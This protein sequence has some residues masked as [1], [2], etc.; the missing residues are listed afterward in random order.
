MFD[1]TFLNNFVKTAAVPIQ[2]LSWLDID[3]EEY[4]RNERLPNNK[5]T[6]NSKDQLRELWDH[7]V[8][9]GPSQFSL[10]PNADRKPPLTKDAGV[11]EEDVKDLLRRTRLAMAQGKTGIEVSNFIRQNFDKHTIQAS[12]GGLQ[13]ISKEHGLLGFAYVDPGVFNCQKTKVSTLKQTFP[14]FALKRAKCD[15]CSF[16]SNQTCLKFELP[17]KERIAFSTEIADKFSKKVGSLGFEFVDDT[18]LSPSERIRKIFLTKKEKTSQRLSSF[19]QNRIAQVN[20]NASDVDRLLEEREKQAQTEVNRLKSAEESALVGEVVGFLKTCFIHG[21]YGENAV[22]SLRKRFATENLKLAEKE[23]RSL[24][25]EQGLFGGVYITL[26]ALGGCDNVAKILKEAN[27]TTRF[28]EKMPRCSSC[29]HAK[30]ER[31][32]KLDLV[33]LDKDIP[34]NDETFNYF[35]EAISHKKQIPKETIL[36]KVGHIRDKRLRFK[37][38][39]LLEAEPE[40]RLGGQQASLHALGQTS[41]DSD[42]ERNAR[43]VQRIKQAL[44]SGISLKAIRTKVETIVPGSLIPSLMKRA[45][46]EIGIISAKSF[47]YCQKLGSQGFSLSKT[48]S[49]SQKSSCADC[50][51]NSKVYCTKLGRKFVGANFKI[52]KTGTTDSTASEIKEFF[53]NSKVTIKVDPKPEAF[54]GEIEGLNEFTIE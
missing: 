13:E 50:L 29:V 37:K 10:I 19:P 32:L 35:V 36:S 18:S 28:L 25:K 46:S 17:L 12:L 11:N 21:I 7:K 44:E 1:D 53:K 51:F 16:N 48:A 54:E 22:S 34:I 3:E 23:V 2:D 24:F 4:R 27:S 41:I 14:E 31:C 5:K 6:L 9:R 43:T 49:V 47:E 52:A 33:F 15:D 38:L 26:G 20:I 42:L 30:D 40:I 8:Y 45:F 39:C